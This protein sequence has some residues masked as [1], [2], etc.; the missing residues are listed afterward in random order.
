[1]EWKVHKGALFNINANLKKDYAATKQNRTKQNKTR[2]DKR[3][4]DKTK[5]NKTADIFVSLSTLLFSS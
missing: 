4:Q 1:L 5:Q 3:R 2:Q